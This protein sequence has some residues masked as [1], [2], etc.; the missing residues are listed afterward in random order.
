VRVLEE[1]YFPQKKTPGEFLNGKRIERN[2]LNFISREI[3]EK[4]GKETLRAGKGKPVG[5]AAR[6]RTA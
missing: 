5:K 4:G 1:A 2:C 3:K 6:K